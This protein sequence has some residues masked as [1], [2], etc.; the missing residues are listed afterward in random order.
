M[1][2]AEFE[3]AFYKGHRSYD[4]RVGDWWITK[5]LDGPHQRA[6]KN[7]AGYIQSFLRAKKIPRPRI[8][9]DYACGNGVYL[10]HVGKAFPGTTIVAIDG[11]RKMLKQAR[12]HLAQ[13]RLDAEFAPAETY[14][15]KRNSQYLLVETPLPNF[16]MPQGKAD[17]VVFLFPN[18]SSTDQQMEV[19]SKY[20][21]DPATYGT[22]RLIAK[23]RKLVPDPIEATATL[24]EITDNLLF[25]RIVS[26]NIHHLLKK[27]GVWFKVEYSGCS[28]EELNELERWECLFSESAMDVSVNGKKQRK[29]FR[30]M[31]DRFFRSSVIRDVYDQSHDPDHKFGGYFI[32]AFEALKP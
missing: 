30:S 25:E 19:L 8:L 20:V 29:L 4:T 22:A 3:A 5:S 13:F 17:V 23:I 18:M 24:K 12:N 10:K 26:I 21:K 14:H 2:Q 1:K 9:I 28:R 7:I 31:G 27:G 6:Y 16:F 15:L 32:S 11:S